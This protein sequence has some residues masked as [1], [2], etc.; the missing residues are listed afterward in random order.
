MNCGVSWSRGHDSGTNVWMKCNRNAAYNQFLFIIK[1]FA[2]ID[3]SRRVLCNDLLTH[4]INY[5]ML[6]YGM[7]KV[8]YQKF[9]LLQHLNYWAE[10]SLSFR[11]ISMFMNIIA[12]G[13]QVTFKRL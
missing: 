1:T 2:D 5:Q 6:D 7:H 4:Q 9:L 11:Q 12:W 8:T 3:R 10:L 13:P